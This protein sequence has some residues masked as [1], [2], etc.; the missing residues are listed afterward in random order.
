MGTRSIIFIVPCIIQ[1]CI[2]GMCVENLGGHFRILPT[3]F[4][5]IKAQL[6]R[7]TNCGQLLLCVS[8]VLFEFWLPTSNQGLLYIVNMQLYIR[9]LEY[10]FVIRQTRVEFHIPFT[11]CIILSE[12]ISLHFQC[13]HPKNRIND[14]NYFRGIS[15]TNVQKVFSTILMCQ[16][17]NKL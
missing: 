6:I 16:L 3:T 9:S 12:L 5:R 11:D 8:V 2:H 14:G 15:E 1:G 10:N 7:L 13:L 4:K 17:L